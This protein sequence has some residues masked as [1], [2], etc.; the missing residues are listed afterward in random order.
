MRSRA[1]AASYK[2]LR[3]QKNQDKRSTYLHFIITE[4]AKES[5]FLIS[6]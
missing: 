6:N 4:G 5:S 1:K 2:R 3:Q